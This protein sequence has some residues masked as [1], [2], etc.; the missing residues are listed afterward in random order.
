MSDT[1]AFEQL[2]LE[3]VSLFLILCRQADTRSSGMFTARFVEGNVQT[4]CDDR[5]GSGSDANNSQQ[6][7]QVSGVMSSSDMRLQTQALVQSQTLSSTSPQSNAK[8]GLPPQCV[9]QNGC[10]STSPVPPRFGMPNAMMTTTTTMK[11]VPGFPATPTPARVARDRVKSEGV[12]NMGVT[13]CISDGNNVGSR[14]RDAGD[15]TMTSGSGSGSVSSPLVDVRSYPR[16]QVPPLAV[17]RERTVGAVGVGEVRDKR[18]RGGE[19]YVERGAKRAR[20]C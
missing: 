6:R 4:S 13:G 16:I 11:A 14:S 10:R 17:L 1:S 19:G 20:I 18:A 2:Q 7:A 12:K 5:S 9:I 15:F 3:F 8:Y